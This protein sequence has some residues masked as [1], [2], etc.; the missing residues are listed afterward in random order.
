MILLPYMMKYTICLPK[1]ELFENSAVQIKLL[2]LNRCHLSGPF[3]ANIYLF[4]SLICY[5]KKMRIF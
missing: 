2:I 3:V 5:K 4:N 1:F